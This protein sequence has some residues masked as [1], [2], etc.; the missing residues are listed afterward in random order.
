MR[1]LRN[2]TALFFDTGTKLLCK[3]RFYP[4][5]FVF[6]NEDFALHLLPQFLHQPDVY[7]PS[8]PV[9]S[10]SEISVAKNQ[11]EAFGFVRN[12]IN[13]QRKQCR[14]ETWC[15]WQ[16][17]EEDTVAWFPVESLNLTYFAWQRLLLSK[18]ASHQSPTGRK[19]TNW[20]QNTKN[21][22]ETK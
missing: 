22:D 4:Y 5:R 13:L 7:H 20:N 10:T 12:F 1:N 18:H 2:A 3:A 21:F 8:I 16:C 19:G 17:R 6:T 9:G 11:D 15:Q 14:K